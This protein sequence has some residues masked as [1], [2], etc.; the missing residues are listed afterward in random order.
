VT[1]PILRPHAV[2]RKNGVW[3]TIGFG[4]LLRLTSALLVA[5][6]LVGCNGVTNLDHGRVN[7][8]SAPTLTIT[9]TP[10]SITL[11]SS[12]TLAWTSTDATTVT[13]DH[14][15]GQVQPSGSLQQKPPAT[16]T[17]NAT[18]TGPGGTA[19]ASVTVVVGGQQGF[20]FTASPAT[21]TAGQSSTLTFSAPGA[22]SVSIDHGIGTLGA[23]GSVTVT[24]ATTTTYTATAS[25]NSSTMTATVTVTVQSSSG[26][27]VSLTANPATISAGQNTTLSWTS[28]NVASLTIDQGV[29]AVA[30]PSGS[31]TVSPNATTVYTITALPGGATA[32]ATVS[33]NSGISQLG[34][35]FTYKF[36]N[37]RTGQNLNESVLTPANVKA[38]EFGKVFTFAVDGE[39]YGQPLY[40]RSVEI[41]GQGTHN[42]VYVATEHDSVYAFDAD[43]KTKSPLWHVSFIDPSS[44]ITAVPQA[45]VGS[46]I[47]PEIGITSTPVIDPGTGTLYVDASTKE[48]GSYFHRLHALDLASGN[49]K[50]GGPVA[51]S[52]SVS[53]SGDGNDGNGHVAFQAKIELQRAGLLLLNNTVYIA[54]ASHGDNGPYHGWVFAYDATIL[55]Q[56]G[57]WNATPN[58]NAGGIWQAGGGL[59]ADSAGSIYGISGN[60]LADGGRDYGDTFF[61]LTLGSGGLS[62]GDFFTPFDQKNLSAH[63]ID[64]GSGGPLL[65]PDQ[66]GSHP[67]LL[68]SAGKAGTIYLIDRDDMGGYNTATDNV[69]QKIPTAV[70]NNGADDNNFCTPTYWQ[71]QVYYVGAVDVAKA[72][73]LNNGTLSTTPQSQSSHVFTSQG[74][75]PAISASGNTNGILWAIDRAGV[76]YAYDATNLAT[77]LYNSSQA[78]TRDTL[79][80]AVRFTVP[81]IANGRVYVGAKGQLVVYGLLP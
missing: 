23:S 56:V 16:T 39:V 30:V 60:G 35:V 22:T 72:F 54:F 65:L 58:G 78:G 61:R 6:F 5:G 79:G 42:V 21:I 71:G 33:V 59:A 74:A 50:F 43:G 19:Q 25:F 29:G 51:I 64:L 18:A 28:A 31:V 2:C 7:H 37:L 67:H 14:G 41:S 40:V 76:L 8:S 45:D 26:G 48:N 15:I 11:G 4:D 46:T 73:T 80:T 34:G 49:E 75:T 13:F 53:G 38:S 24:P 55:K 70:G 3:I 20:Q 57:I 47:Y 36:D 66:P 12:T 10:S 1:S 77:E 68:T 32:S 9:A 63:D 27:S 44:G 81:T 69:V 52:G 62:V 17:Y